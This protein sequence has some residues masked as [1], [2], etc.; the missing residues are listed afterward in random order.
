VALAEREHESP[1]R[2]Q[3]NLVRVAA[4]SHFRRP[5]E[6]LDV[7]EKKDS[8]VVTSSRNFESIS[9]VGTKM[10]ICHILDPT[11]K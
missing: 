6:D 5:L 8:G 2:S 1:A 10:S 9:Q 11:R 3:K 4:K 7:L